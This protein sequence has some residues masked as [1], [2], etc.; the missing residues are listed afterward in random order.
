MKPKTLFAALV[1]AGAATVL[2]PSAGYAG[3][4]QPMCV[5]YGQ[6]KDGY[7]LPY[8]RDADVIL[9]H[10]TN[11]IARQTISG[12]L[13]PGVNFALYVHLDDGRTATPYSPRALRT[14]DLVEGDVT[15]LQAVRAA[16][17][18]SAARRLHADLGMPLDK[19][20]HYL[21]HSSVS[22]TMGYLRARQEIAES[23]L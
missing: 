16:L 11:E 19:V 17:R 22:T 1:L 10:G 23:V 12:S 14:G 6:A 4:P 20:R 18:R 15:D 8:L 21:R 3:L 7:G 9:R 13:R 2:L 5:Y